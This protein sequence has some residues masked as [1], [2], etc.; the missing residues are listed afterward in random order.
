MR[1]SRDKLE[2]NISPSGRCVMWL[3]RRCCHQERSQA[4]DDVDLLGGRTEKEGELKVTKTQWSR[5]LITGHP[6][7]CLWPLQEGEPATALTACLVFC[8]S[9]EKHS[10]ESDCVIHCPNPATFESERGAISNYTRTTDRSR[11]HSR[12]IGLL[13]HPNLNC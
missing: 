13:G 2:E 7:N 10:E 1:C 8:N 9:N 6:W 12:H 11:D 4:G 3:L 5:L